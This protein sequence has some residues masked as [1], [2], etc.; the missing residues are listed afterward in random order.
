MTLPPNG[1]GTNKPE[2]DPLGGMDPMA[3]LESLARRQGANPEELITAA[4]LD[5]PLPSAEQPAERPRPQASNEPPA[6]EPALSS[7]DDPLG[8]MDPMAWLESL[9]RRQ[10]ANPEELITAADLDVPL[11]SAEQPA[12][13]PRPQASNE[14]PA[15][16][17]ALSNADDPLGGMDPMAW[18]ESLA[19]RQGANPEELITAADLDVP[20]PSAELPAESPR[21]QAS[22][23]PSAPE[24]ALSSADDPLGG[25]DPMAWLESLARRQGANPEELITAADLDVPLPSAEAEITAPGYTDFDPFSAG[26]LSA[27]ARAV[28][29]L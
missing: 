12:E 27:S 5:V 15:P 23:E 20:L 19:R 9:A 21:P 25:M 29:P 6:P 16:E 8:G 18:L 28:E 11:P 1:E 10:G 14:P 17:P 22:N 7:A 26:A 13:R 4:D 24:P 3:W 2:D